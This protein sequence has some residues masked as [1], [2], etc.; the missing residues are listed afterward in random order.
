MARSRKKG[1]PVDGVLVLDKPD[2]MTSNAALQT[3]KRAFNARKAGHTGSLDPLATGV[4]PICFGQATRFSQFLLEA[5]KSYEAT[6]RLGVATDS[7]DADGTVIAT[8]PVPALDETSWERAL[9]GFRGPIEQVPNMFSAIKIDGQPLYKLARQGI[10][11]ERA[12]RP[13][14]I[15]ELTLLDYSA[16]EVRLHVR[17]SKGTYIR[18]L[19]QDIGDEIGCGAHVTCLRRTSS[20]PFDINTAVP[21]TRIVAL[22]EMRDFDSLARYLSPVSS[23]VSQLP[24]VTL[25]TLSAHYLRQ[26]QPVQVARAPTD[27]LVQLFEETGDELSF[28]GVGGIDDDGLVAPRRL[29]SEAQE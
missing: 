11:V 7:G 4:L 21:L 26:G 17:C 20:G 14:T 13:V 5:D 25:P 27:G 6:I 16:D 29:M 18:C 2:G 8:S 12:S 19:A 3:V 1:R 28:M 23:A 10:E 22:Q 24:S 15:H 9:S